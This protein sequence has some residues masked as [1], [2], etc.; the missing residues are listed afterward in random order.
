VL[1]REGEQAQLAPQQGLS[2]L[3]A[4]VERVRDEGLQVE[5]RVIGDPRA[6]AAGVDLTAYRVL[7][8]ALLAARE[9]DASRATTILRYG[10]QELELEVSDDR[11]GGASDRLPGLRDRVGLYGG[12]LRAERRGESGFRLRANLP[13]ER[14]EA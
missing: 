13:V 5:L 11:R 9:N 8:D 1:R 6:L 7:E 4:L 14:T 2:R 10:D 12:H 3:D